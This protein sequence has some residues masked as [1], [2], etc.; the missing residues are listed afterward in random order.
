MY[1]RLRLAALCMSFK[2]ICIAT[3][4]FYTDVH[5]QNYFSICFLVKLENIMAGFRKLIILV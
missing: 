4:K 1:V 2:T 3:M 5:L